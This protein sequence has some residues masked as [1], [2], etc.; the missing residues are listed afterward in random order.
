MGPICSLYI[1]LHNYSKKIDHHHKSSLEENAI[2]VKELQR[3]QELIKEMQQDHKSEL[4]KMN[5]K[6]QRAYH[7]RDSL[8]ETLADMEKR[9]K[10]LQNKLS[11][12]N[13]TMSQQ[14]SLR[15]HQQSIKE[16]QQMLDELMATHEAVT[17]AQADKLKSLKREK[18]SLTSKLAE[19]KNIIVELESQCTGLHKVNR[20]LK[21]EMDRLQENMEMSRD[22]ENFVHNELSKAILKVEKTTVER[23]ALAQLAHS[24]QLTT[25]RAVEKRKKDKTTIK[26]LKRKLNQPQLATGEAVTIDEI[27]Y[28]YSTDHELA[29]QQEHCQEAIKHIRSLERSKQEELRKTTSSLR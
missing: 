9:Q 15:E 4:S 16:L 6:L 29:W 17:T 3:Q 26:H 14:I 18:K 1:L 12:A 19:A 27:D 11:L 28:A 7:D 10:H 21:E 22:R 5:R 8:I 25:E 2:L 23:D 20:K 24:Q 13:E